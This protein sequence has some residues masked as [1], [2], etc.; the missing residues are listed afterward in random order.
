MR[1]AVVT[2]SAT[3]ITSVERSGDVIL[4]ESAVASIT[5]IHFVR[6]VEFL[7]GKLGLDDRWISIMIA[8]CSRACKEISINLRTGDHIDIR[9]YIKVKRVPGGLLS[10]CL[11]VDGVVAKKNVA[12]KKM[13]STVINPRILL[14]S[15]SLEYER[16]ENKMSTLTS[17]LEEEREY[18]SIVTTK[19]AGLQPDVIVVEKSVSRVAQE[20]LMT[21]GATLVVGMKPSIIEK[22]SRCS[23][24]EVVFSTD[25]IIRPRIGTCTEFDVKPFFDA[26]KSLMFFSGCDSSRGCTILLRGDTLEVLTKVKR[27]IMFAMFVRYHLNLEASYVADLFG[28]LIYPVWSTIDPTPFDEYAM[29]EPHAL[30][31]IS[32]T[33]SYTA[34]LPSKKRIAPT[35]GLP[36][37]SEDCPP[38]RVEGHW[39]HARLSVDDPEAQRVLV[40]L[41]V[42]PK[43]DAVEECKPAE[44]LDIVAY[45]ESDLTL[46]YYL[47]EYCFAPSRHCQN[48]KCSRSIFEHE[49]IF[50]HH[51]ARIRISVTQTP[52]AIAPR[53]DAI[54]TRVQ[55]SKC[56]KRSKLNMMSD[57]C[58]HLSL[59]KFIESC[60]YATNLI[61]VLPDCGHDINR[62]S[63]VVLSASLLQ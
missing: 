56:D 28:T 35:S 62:Y 49:N 50:T 43:V 20:M 45:S 8:L 54:Y 34:N 48:P 52:V 39:S 18:L 41:S 27:G 33:I 21:A 1:N 60:C 57:K 25:K 15:C 23:G 22:L 53:N 7:V 58:Y 55:C 16:V 44:L 19:I 63:S 26:K 29:D 4:R 42:R 3:P 36:S 61:S 32:P 2:S 46:G 30:L 17:L 24:A 9:H 11:Y 12:H 31:S 13:R 5:D 37:I 10:D 40:L 38:L 6:L 59:G 47:S 51:K 14:L